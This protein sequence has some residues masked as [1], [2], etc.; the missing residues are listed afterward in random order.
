MLKKLQL[1]PNDLVTC[2]L[3]NVALLELNLDV[4]FF[5]FLRM[6]TRCH[7]EPRNASI[8]KTNCHDE[9]WSNMHTA[10]TQN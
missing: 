10:H 8:N 3:L 2:T 6:S 4:C 9:N 1:L 7:F 5:F